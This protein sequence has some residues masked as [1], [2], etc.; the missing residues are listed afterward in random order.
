MTVIFILFERLRVMQFST[1]VEVEDTRP[2]MHEGDVKCGQKL[3]LRCCAVLLL[4]EEFD[5]V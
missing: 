3:M 2:G 5:L 1:V 4:D